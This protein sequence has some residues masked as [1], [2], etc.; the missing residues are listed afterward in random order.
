LNFH[1]FIFSQNGILEDFYFYEAA[2]TD[3]MDNP[4]SL[5][6]FHPIALHNSFPFPPTLFP[7]SIPVKSIP[8]LSPI[9]SSISLFI[10]PSE[11]LLP[12]GQLKESSKS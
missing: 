6:P 11:L 8:Q 4:V 10:L 2:T 1:H 12:A 3:P 7:F 9:L 5:I